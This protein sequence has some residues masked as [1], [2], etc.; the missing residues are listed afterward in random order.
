MGKRVRV[1]GIRMYYE[2]AG[3]G[4]RP[5]VLLHGFSGSQDDFADGYPMP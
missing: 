3:S 4:D 1:G 2:E 5:F